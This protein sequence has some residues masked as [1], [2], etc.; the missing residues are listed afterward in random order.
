LFARAA[1]NAGKNPKLCVCAFSRGFSKTAGRAGGSDRA[2]P[3]SYPRPDRSERVCAHARAAAASHAIITTSS[4]D[5]ERDRH[6]WPLSTAGCRLL[7]SASMDRNILDMTLI[8][9]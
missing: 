3:K 1:G 7:R 2:D 8:Q 4:S 9:L 6:P 5:K